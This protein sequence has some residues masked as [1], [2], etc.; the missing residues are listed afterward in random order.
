MRKNVS[1]AETS[2][3]LGFTITSNDLTMVGVSTTDRAVTLTGPDSRGAVSVLINIGQIDF[4][5][6]FHIISINV[7][8]KSSRRQ[9]DNVDIIIVLVGTPNPP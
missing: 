3:T 6:G 8:E 1:P 5:Q 2:V 4:V 7:I 9:L